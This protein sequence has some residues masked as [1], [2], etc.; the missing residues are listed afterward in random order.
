MKSRDTPP[1]PGGSPNGEGGNAGQGP[2]RELTF[3]KKRYE[4]WESN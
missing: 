2:F 1:I 3:V 4:S